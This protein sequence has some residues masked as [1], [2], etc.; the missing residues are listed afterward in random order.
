M[1]CVQTS[2]NAWR[3]LQCVRTVAVRILKDHFD[4]C[5]MAGLR[6]ASTET[7]SVSLHSNPIYY[8]PAFTQQMLTNVNTCVNENFQ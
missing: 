5:V 3:S 8:G 7:V 2:T 6:S 4:V 1:Y